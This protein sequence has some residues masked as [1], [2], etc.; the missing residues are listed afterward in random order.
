MAPLMNMQQSEA[1]YHADQLMKLMEEMRVAENRYRNANR[2][3][4]LHLLIAALVALTAALT[5]T[6]WFS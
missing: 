6:W 5:A 4:N 3:A 2:R 1:D